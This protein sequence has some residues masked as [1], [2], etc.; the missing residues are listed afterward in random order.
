MARW[1]PWVVNQDQFTEVKL[2]GESLPFGLMKN[3]LIVVVPVGNKEGATVVLTLCVAVE[4]V[5]GRTAHNN[6]WN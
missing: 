6:V 5:E 2:V 1:V 3:P 4:A